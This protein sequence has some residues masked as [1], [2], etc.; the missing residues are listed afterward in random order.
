MTTRKQPSAS[1]RIRIRLPGNDYVFWGPP[2]TYKTIRWNPTE[3][4]LKGDNGCEH[5]IEE[6]GTWIKSAAEMNAEICLFRC[7][8]CGIRGEAGCPWVWK[9]SWKKHEA[10][11]AAHPEEEKDE[12]AEK[13]C[14]R[15]NQ[16]IPSR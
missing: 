9:T 6:I 16:I 3:D 10:Y 8:K 11:W 12:P 5:E 1:R 13:R 14:P 15:C 7:P 4:E 2:P